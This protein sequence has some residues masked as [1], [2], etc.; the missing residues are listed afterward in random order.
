[1]RQQV[2]K[3]EPLAIPMKLTIAVDNGL[4]SADVLAHYRSGLTG[5]VKALPPD[6]EITLITTAP[7]P[8][9]VVRPTT[10]RTADSAR[11]QRLRA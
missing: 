9:T 10:D 7:Q 3:V 1:M 4:D 5:L 11:R 6:V 2:V 8:R